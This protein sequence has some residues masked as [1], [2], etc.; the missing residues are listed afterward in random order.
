MPRN[1]SDVRALSTAQPAK[2]LVDMVKTASD[3]LT[4]ID[5]ADVKKIGQRLKKGEKFDKALPD[6]ANPSRKVLPIHRAVE[7]GNTKVLE[8][9]VDG[10]ADVNAADGEGSASLHWAAT[11][12]SNADSTALIG[13]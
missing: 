2:L 12:N 7:A 13:E 11:S 1:S 6:P 4:E 10:G 8:L 3:L 5:E 9:L